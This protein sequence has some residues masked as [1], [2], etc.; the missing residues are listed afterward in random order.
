MATKPAKKPV[1]NNTEK[2]YVDRRMV[3]FANMDDIR[4]K[5]AALGKAIR[6]WVKLMN[7]E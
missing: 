3:Y 5:Q 1:V 4:V 7:Q 6:K 2:V